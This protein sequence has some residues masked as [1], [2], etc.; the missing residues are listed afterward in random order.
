MSE[1]PY[2][3]YPSHRDDFGP[4]DRYDGQQ[5]LSIPAVLSLVSSLVCCIPGMGLL[6]LLLGFV[7]LINI[8]RSNGRLTGTPA[9]VVGMALG[10]LVSVGWVALAWGAGSGLNFWATNITPPMSRLVEAAYDGDVAAARAEMTVGAAGQVTDDEILRF[11]QAMRAEFG[12]FQGMPDGLSEWMQAVGEGFSRSGN[13]FQGSSQTA[14][15]TVLFTDAGGV[16]I[17]G[18]FDPQGQPSKMFRYEDLFVLLPNG[19]ALTLRD[20]GPAKREAIRINMN[21]VTSAEYL[22]R[23]ANPAAAPTAPAPDAV[24]ETPV[25]PDEPDA[26]SPG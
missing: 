3:A 20:D 2:A 26:P 14:V 13:K 24:P 17:F 4:D 19:E 5:R 25:D 7:G 18:V 15:P 1:N 6:A 10:V 12:A 22:E 23:A 11:G 9:A 16:A 21:P 8:S